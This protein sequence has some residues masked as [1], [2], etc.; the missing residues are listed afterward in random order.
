MLQFSIR[1]LK[2][3]NE[4]IKSLENLIDGKN[5]SCAILP[6]QTVQ[7][8]EMKVFREIRFNDHN[9]LRECDE[10]GVV[11]KLHYTWIKKNEGL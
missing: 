6:S 10:H 5:N 11:P 9:V 2:I 3:C 4:V 8:S 7:V 1:K